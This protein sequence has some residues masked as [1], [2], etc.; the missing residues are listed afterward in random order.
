MKES[1]LPAF[2]TLVNL[3]RRDPEALERLRRQEVETVISRAPPHLQRRL[4]GLQFQIDSQIR[5]QGSSLGACIKI[6]Q[7][8]HESFAQLRCLLNQLA[9]KNQPPP[10]AMIEA[11]S[12]AKLLPFRRDAGR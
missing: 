8:M 2:D 1:G 4:R 11:R 6:S 7:M 12:P 10:L 5:L 9:E 3:A